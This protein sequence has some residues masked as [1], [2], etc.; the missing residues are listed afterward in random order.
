MPDD[1][2]RSSHG[3]PPE[4]RPT[5]VPP[6]W[7][8]LL[9]SDEL[10]D[11]LGDA[12]P[13]RADRWTRHDIPLRSL[14]G[15]GWPHAPRGWRAWV[16]NVTLMAIAAVLLVLGLGYTTPR[17][18]AAILLLFGVLTLLAVVGVQIVRR[19]NRRY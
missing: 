1:N 11:D 4:S 7:W 5:N 2:F 8:S 14:P 6:R 3:P 12:D 16:I 15:R 13:G 9:E 10:P 18:V 19:T 17:G